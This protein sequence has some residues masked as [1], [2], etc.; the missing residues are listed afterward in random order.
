[1][2]HGRPPEAL[3][4]HKRIKNKIFFPAGQ[5]DAAENAVCRNFRLV[6]GHIQ[7][8]RNIQFGAEVTGH[9]QRRIEYRSTVPAKR[10][11]DQN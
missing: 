3:R 7:L 2:S 1:V 5:N 11:N 10:A 6:T 9:T 4:G 8:R